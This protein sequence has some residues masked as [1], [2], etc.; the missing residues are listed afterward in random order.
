MEVIKISCD[1]VVEVVDL[2]DDHIFD[3]MYDLLGGFEIVRTRE[4]KHTFCFNAVMV[5]DD[6][7]FAHGKPYNRYASDFYAGDICGDVLI[8]CEE[9]ADFVPF[10][11][12][13]ELIEHVVVSDFLIRFNAFPFKGVQ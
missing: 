3:S 6:N 1:D 8:A 2:D 7:F 11:V 4:L 5:V 12:P 13:A 10:P 9:D